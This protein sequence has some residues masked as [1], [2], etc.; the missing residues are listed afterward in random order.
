MCVWNACYSSFCISNVKNLDIHKKEI[1][2]SIKYNLTISYQ[3]SSSNC[4]PKFHDARTKTSLQHPAKQRKNVDPRVDRLRRRCCCGVLFVS[5]LWRS[6]DVVCFAAWLGLAM[7]FLSHEGPCLPGIELAAKHLLRIGVALLGVRITYGQIA[8]LGWEAIAMVVGSVIATIG[9]GVLLARL[10]GF[11][12]SFGVLTGGAVAICG[13]SAAM[14][15]SSVMPTHSMK[16]RSTLFTVVVVSTL[17]TLAMVFYPMLA[18]ALNLQ[19]HVVGIFLGATIHDVAQVVGAG[20]GV[21]VETGDTATVVKLMR[22]AML[23]PVMLILVAVYRRNKTNDQTDPTPIPWFVA[24]FVLLV[25]AGSM[26]W[27]PVWTQA[28]G[29]DLSRWLL[30]IAIAAIG[31]KTRLQEIVAVGIRPVLLMVGETTFLAV[32]VL[33]VIA[34]THLGSNS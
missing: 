3:V 34:L 9:V 19:D 24:I 11:S 7:N 15:L 6:G 18:Q 32:V 2:Y 23:V 14:A 30:I 20:Y 10:L 13:A 29:N 33:S 28:I 12:A 26:G 31:L 25:V 4:L 27:I 16:E 8:Q 5:T 17:S 21:S 22:V 1:Q